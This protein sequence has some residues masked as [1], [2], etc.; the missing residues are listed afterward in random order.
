[1][2][3]TNDGPS[4]WLAR[5]TPPI[6]ADV[7]IVGG[8]LVGLSTAWWM[9]RLLRDTSK[10]VLLLE[11]GGLAG[12]ASGRNAGFLL[13]GSAE[14]YTRFAA[15]AGEDRAFAFWQLSYDNRELV[16]AELLD[17][18]IVDAEFVPE[19]SWI[20]SLDQEAQTR[21]LRE[22][23]ERLLAKGFFGGEQGLRW[24]E[25]D[26]LRRA[27][28]SDRLG[29]ALHQPRDGGID[30]VRLARGLASTAQAQHDGLEL[31]TGVRVRTLEPTNDGRVHLHTESGEV[32]AER[33]VLALNAY[34]PQLLSHLDGVVR[35][36]R[37]QVLATAPQ[38]RLLP[39]VWYID[40][41][42]Q[43]LRQ[44]PDGTLILGGCRNVAPEEEVGYEETPNP[45]I[46]VAL[47]TFLRD[48][49]P[50]L[51]EAPVVR[52]WAGIMAWTDTGLPEIGDVPGVPGALYAAGMNGHGLSLGFV[53]GRYLARRA[54]GE[55]VGELVP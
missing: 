17:G 42:F 44:L 52:R 11:A 49:F 37:G 43:Y 40:D 54:L 8:G 50:R 19:G 26:E 32:I 53:T 13:T 46:Q 2:R 39:G 30:P 34:A 29:G 47:D 14:P 28:G 23:A 21:E 12:R 55:D 36:V 48:A 35:P 31:R 33:V 18:G 10:R 45:K 38:A 7:V 22:S 5:P 27:S 6:E 25:G 3:S 20:A 41:G 1:M 16:R 9:S 24:V 4:F 15:E 51:A